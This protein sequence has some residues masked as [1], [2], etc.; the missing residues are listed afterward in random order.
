MN[1]VMS[2]IRKYSGQAVFVTSVL[3]VLLVAVT[4]LRGFLSQQL[5]NLS[6]GMLAIPFVIRTRPDKKGSYRF[7]IV[8][9]LL[10]ALSFYA[11]VNTL[12][13]FALVAILLFL[14]EN[15]YGRV[16]LLTI[17]VVI[18]TMPLA[19]YMV[20]TFSFP[21]RLWLTSVCGS[22]FRIAGIPVE[23]AG[24]TFTFEGNDFTV[25]P[26]CMGLNM[27]I[28]SFIIGLLLFG[29]YQKRC[30]REM[31][32]WTVLAY[33]GIVLLLNIFSNLVRMMLLVLF[34]VFPGTVMH[35]TIG[36]ICLLVQV[37]IPSWI[38][39]RFLIKPISPMSSLPGKED[40][41][42]N[43][44][45][46]Y[47]PAPTTVFRRNGLWKGFTQLVCCILLWIAALQVVEKKSD[48]AA[49]ASVATVTGYVATPHSK[50]IVK[51]E[52]NASLVYIKQI[53]WFCDTE[54]NPMTCW[55]GSG[56]KMSQVQETVL[57]ALTMYTGILQKDEDTLYT[58][59][60][61]GNG[62]SAT[63]S[64]LQWRWDM[65]T[66]APAYSLINVTTANRELL[67]EEITKVADLFAAKEGNHV[68]M[69]FID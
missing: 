20:N 32:V 31:P 68:S 62:T 4:C 16:N 44:A 39:C 46:I 8:A 13:Y 64:Q 63:N 3:S 41:Q 22:I 42:P 24:N 19:T 25:D 29:Y 10:M 69:S 43:N 17:A 15:R 52:N 36:I 67:D 23:V 1:D 57:G 65:F 35:D 55:S 27:L 14:V 5:F 40:V 9:L 48:N 12:V 18:L 49:P 2:G 47:V 45:Q 56:Y 37:V 6:L 54:H 33:L 26:A 59:W 53:R 11:P 21:V 7:A 61:Y 58:A 28:T 60:W 66:G 38:V 30:G 50:G 51:L 34:Q